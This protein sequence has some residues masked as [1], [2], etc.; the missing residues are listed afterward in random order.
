MPNTKIN[1]RGTRM[2]KLLFRLAALIFW[3]A[4]LIFLALV[5]WRIAAGVFCWLFANN[6]EH[7]VQEYEKDK[8]S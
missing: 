5:D 1:A 2:A 7:A 8:V 3:V 6:L 4:G